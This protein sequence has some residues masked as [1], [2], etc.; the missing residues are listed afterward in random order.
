[1]WVLLAAQ[2]AVL[3]GVLHMSI[4]LVSI[5]EAFLAELADGVALKT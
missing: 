4:Q 2:E 3:V 5:V 1:V